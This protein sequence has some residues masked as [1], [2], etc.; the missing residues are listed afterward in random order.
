MT[1]VTFNN[2]TKH[3]GTQD[4]LSDVAFSI[5]EREKIGLVGANGAGKTT[6]LRLLLGLEEC[7]SGAIGTAPSLSIGYIPQALEYGDGLASDYL[8]ET[9]REKEAALRAAEAALAVTPEERLEELVKRFEQIARNRPDPAWGKR[10]RARRTQLEKTRERATE[11]PELGRN[12]IRVELQ[13]ER[14]RADIAVSVSG[15][16]RAFDGRVLF[17]SAALEIRCGERV[18]LV[19]P[20]GSG[21][22][23]FIRDLL[24][25]ASWDNPV[26]R[27][28]PSLTVGYCAQNQEVLDH[29]K[30]VLDEFLSLGRITENEVFTLLSRFLFTRADLGK[31]IGSLSGGERNR[32]QLAR[33]IRLGA[34]FLV[35]DEPTNHMDIPS[36]EALEDALAEFE[37]TVLV[38][39]HDRYFLDKIATS[40][41]EIQEC[42]FRKYYGNFSEFWAEKQAALRSLEARVTTRARQYRSPG[43]DRNG[44]GTE[45]GA[46]AAGSGSRKNAAGNAGPGR[47]SREADAAERLILQLEKEKLELE[48]R[49]EAAFSRG[50]HKEGHRLSQELA[51]L[52]RRLD[53]QYETWAGLG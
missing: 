51:V 37:G 25:N 2:V 22:T 26:F 33:A 11:R 38:V 50:D 23:T 13:A 9:V 17:R 42:G 1:L 43:I 12:S 46:G 14:T 21:K 27:I 7:S 52:V 15:Y 19:G 6:L 48:R 4:V 35:L 47:N 10:L 53:R 3:Y 36:R 39:T 41:V 20:N 18:A 5:Q 28:G 34:N 8:L 32:L 31:R 16:D 49:L 40:I 24:A 29:D 44:A 30:T 45:S